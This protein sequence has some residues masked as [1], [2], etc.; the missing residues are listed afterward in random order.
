[1]FDINA[2]GTPCRRINF[3][4]GW[5]GAQVVRTG[6]RGICFSGL[7]TKDNTGFNRFSGSSAHRLGA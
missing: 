6:G 4:N 7:A 2:I 3:D 1:M 5:Q